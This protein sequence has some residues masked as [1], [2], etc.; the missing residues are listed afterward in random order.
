MR[1]FVT[2]CLIIAAVLASAARTSRAESVTVGNFQFELR[3]GW[4][5]APANFEGSSGGRKFGYEK[6]PGGAS[7][8]S[9]QARR[10]LPR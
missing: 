5:R 2:G 4:E 9:C 3:D 8:P 6:G 1:S 10:D 7:R